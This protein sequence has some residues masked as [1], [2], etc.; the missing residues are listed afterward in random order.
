MNTIEI[1]LL[2]G[3]TIFGHW[4]HGQD[5]LP[6]FVDFIGEN[7]DTLTWTDNQ[8]VHLLLLE[9]SH[10]LSNEEERTIS[11]TIRATH[12]LVKGGQ[13]KKTWSFEDGVKDCPLDVEAKFLTAPRFTDL[14]KDGIYEV[15]FMVQKAC[16]GDISPSEVLVIMVDKENKTYRLEAEQLLVFPDKSTDGGAYDLKDFLQLSQVYQ[17]HAVEYLLK[18]YHF[19]Y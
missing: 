16:K 11:K 12:W 18:N 3:M 7:S 6:P 2:I 8:G 19:E 1:F 4:A 5:Q 14:D 13:H 15:W 10:A 17:D 9:Q